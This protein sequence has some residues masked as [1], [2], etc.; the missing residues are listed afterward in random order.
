MT[1]K[2]RVFRG[3][4]TALVTPFIDSKIDYLAFENLIEYQIENG[5]N[6]IVVLG[7]TGEA[8]TISEEERGEIISFAKDKIRNRVKL[9]VGTGTNSTEST[10]RY[11]KSAYSL[12]ADA[13][14]CV[15]PYYNKPTY[16]G[17]VEHYKQI[18]KEVDLPIILYNVPSR[19]G[20]NIPISVYDALK[21]VENIVAIKEASA[22]M[23]YFGEIKEKYGDSF[24][25]YTGNDDLTLC[26][27]AMGGDGVISVVSNALPKEMTE[28]CDSF[29]E[30]KIEKSL[31]I[32]LGLLKLIRELFWETNPV[33]IK[34]LL[35]QLK[36]CKNEHRLPLFSSTRQ[37]EISFFREKIENGDYRK[38]SL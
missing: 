25:L 30:G 2:Q 8:P 23:G 31:K 35:S 10:V 21:D 7:T 36:M 20:V 22:N 27:L 38:L 15:S 37:K 33:P 32:Q 26:S 1:R 18:A 11:S 12:G 34:E 29:F 4:A 13:L 24:Y 16:G 5:I 9:I 6:A 19:T 28:L 17:M 14:L 3:C